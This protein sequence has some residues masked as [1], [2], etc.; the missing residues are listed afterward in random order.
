MAQRLSRA[1][2]YAAGAGLALLVTSCLPEDDPKGEG[3]GSGGGDSAGP[4][5]GAGGGSGGDGSTLEGR[6]SPGDFTG[7]ASLL[8]TWDVDVDWD[9]ESMTCVVDVEM[10]LTFKVTCDLGAG[11]YDLDCD[12]T[13]SIV[14]ITGKVGGGA[15]DFAIDSIEQ[16]QGSACVS[17]GLPVGA[18]VREPEVEAELNRT[19]AGLG[20]LGGKWVAKFFDW[21]CPLDEC[22]STDRRRDADPETSCDFALESD[23]AIAV[24]CIEVS[25]PEPDEEPWDC[26]STISISGSI[27]AGEVSLTLTET[28]EGSDCEGDPEQPGTITATRR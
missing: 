7:D 26:E 11:E 28:E 16:Y 17:Y 10:G 20:S 5:G 4:G 3:D 12:R 25:A 1:W 2:S 18:D 14:E 21:S 24:S 6:N 13:S 23:G 9:G 15:G 27:D 22:S 19:V 8:G